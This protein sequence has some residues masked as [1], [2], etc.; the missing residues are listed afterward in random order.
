MKQLGEIKTIGGNIFLIYVT[1]GLFLFFS[2]NAFADEA[3]SN[4]FSILESVIASGEYSTSNS[5]ILRDD[6][7]EFM[8]G[9]STA[10]SF[11]LNDGFLFYPFVSTP[12]LAA[13]A[14]N[15][16]VSLSW[17]AAQGFLGWNVSG[18]NIGISTASG[19]GYS[20]SEV[21]NVLSLTKTNLANG[22]K[23][24]FIVRAEDA[25]GNSI[26]T[27]PEV[28][29]TPSSLGGEAG[30][31]G[32]GVIPPFGFGF[33]PPVPS[34]P[35][36]SPLCSRSDLNCDG[37]VNL[38]D[39]SIL[40]TKPEK[41]ERAILSYLF[42]DWTEIL[43]IPFV[44]ASEL[45]LNKKTPQ[46]FSESKELAQAISVFSPA[47]AVPS[48]KSLWSSLKDSILFLF[49]WLREAIKKFL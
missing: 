35:P 37:R 23:Y 32:G 27:S 24:F 30:V 17:T 49:Q 15:T 38:Q 48:A 1:L 36:S 25:F 20:F 46:R 44:S 16:Q 8:I 10:G 13:A 43:P 11:G 3:S 26:V 40:L 22:T 33:G 29:A 41:S 21:G 9:T 18:Y 34:I 2:R 6:F 4:S 5:Y 39:F 31:F 28:S 45:V 14:G 7:D 12:I 19:G 42:S 47:E